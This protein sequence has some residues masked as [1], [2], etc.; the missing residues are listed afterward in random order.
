VAAA[1]QVDLRSLTPIFGIAC[2]PA[3]RSSDV[4]SWPKAAS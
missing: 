1:P 4:Y 3:G 2:L